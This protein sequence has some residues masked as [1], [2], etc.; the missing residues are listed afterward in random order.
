MQVKPDIT[1]IESKK[2]QVKN[3]FD[4]ISHKYDFLNHTLS[5][6]IDKIWRQKAIDSIKPINPKLIL[7]VATGTGDFA[8]EAL[9]LK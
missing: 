4:S 1:S 3:M 6:G 9:K 2:T 7:D 8:I 5:L